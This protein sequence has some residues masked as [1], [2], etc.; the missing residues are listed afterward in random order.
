MSARAEIA[1]A[2]R[3]AGLAGWMAQ[4]W[5]MT[6]WCTVA[7][8]GSYAC[9]Y[10]FRKPF[11][12]ATFAGD[13]ADAGLKTLLVTAQILGYALSKFLGI[14]V[15][16]EMPP[17]RRAW[18]FLGLIGVAELALLVFA[19]TP[20][21]YCAAWLFV[22]GLALG[23]VFGLVLGFVEGRRMTEL[24]VAGLC[25]SFILAD[26]VTKSVGAWL[27]SGGVPERWMPFAAGLVFLLPLVGFVWMLRQIPPPTAQD[28]EARSARVPMSGADRI[29]LV[30]R[31]GVRLV[32]VMVAYLL[33]T[34]LRSVRADFAP[35]IWAGLGLG[36]QPAIFTQSELW[37]TLGVVVANGAL[38][39]IRD[40]RRAFFMSLALAAGGLVLALA[41]V[42]GLQRGVLP[43]F[44]FMVLL[45]FGMYVPYVAVHTTIFE[46]LIA[47]TREWG[48]VGFLMYVADSVGY[49]GYAAVMLS[50]S[51][52]PAKENF[53]EFFLKL[54]GTLIA[55][56]I[57]AIVV[58]IVLY[59]RRAPRA[60]S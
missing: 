13:G 31:H 1:S 20:A 35:E 56:A 2:V 60:E 59:A 30:R 47:L 34:V 57:V 51:A 52:F 8:F 9:M 18:V 33:I 19:V 55:G 11:T 10:G 39:L 36:R 37:V 40:N 5:V 43:P 46:R 42:L 23:L 7:A 50:R 25:A 29:A 3:P 49:I 41:A 48:N 44:A 12:A 26:G 14:K 22:N 27:L 17:A 58:A 38:V 4:P 15:I 24:F 6:V 28:L 45:G 16:A 21:P 54:S 32:G 53:L